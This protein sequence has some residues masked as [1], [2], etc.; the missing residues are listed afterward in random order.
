MAGQAKGGPITMLGVHFSSIVG[1]QCDSGSWDPLV[2]DHAP[3]ML[4]SVGCNPSLK[5]KAA[6]IN[7]EKET[8]KEKETDFG[9]FTRRFARSAGGISELL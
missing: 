5:M 2:K 7:K 3:K 4:S 6:T 9:G 1:L 8:S